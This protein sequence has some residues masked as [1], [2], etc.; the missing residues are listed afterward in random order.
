M[1]QLSTFL[2]KLFSWPTLRRGL[3]Y[4]GS[5]AAVLFIAELSGFIESMEPTTGTVIIGLALAQ[6]TKILNSK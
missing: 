6:V 1:K 3:W 2:S 5:Q 4:A